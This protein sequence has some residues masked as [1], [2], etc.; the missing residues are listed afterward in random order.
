MVILHYFT[1][2]GR[3]RRQHV[4]NVFLLAGDV[5]PDLPLKKSALDEE[6]MF[7]LEHSTN[8]FLNVVRWLKNT[9]VSHPVYRASSPP[10]NKAV[11]SYHFLRALADPDSGVYYTLPGT[12][13]LYASE[14]LLQA[15]LSTPECFFTLHMCISIRISTGDY[16]A[17]EP[18]FIWKQG[19]R[20][21]PA[22]YIMQH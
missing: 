16:V 22:K 14:D 11:S 5:A 18:D 21:V 12:K 9:F 7:L 20:N 2:P 19:A 13:V 10:S 1:S 17:D 15:L 6:A 4:E 8:S 3:N